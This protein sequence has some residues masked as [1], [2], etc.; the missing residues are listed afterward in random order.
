MFKS[1]LA[2]DPEMFADTYTIFGTSGM[3]MI[4]KRD[5]QGKLSKDN[6]KIKGR[7]ILLN[8]TVTN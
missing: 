3:E 6:T 5:Q 7:D 4:N 8:L 1:E 2:R